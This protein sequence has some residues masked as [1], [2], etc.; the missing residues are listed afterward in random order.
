M[1]TSKQSENKPAK[2]NSEGETAVD[3]SEENSEIM[4]LTQDINFFQSKLDIL[5]ERKKKIHL[6]CDQ[7]SGW[8]SKVHN[9]MS[10]L[11]DKHS[12]GTTAKMQMSE[13]FK[14]ISEM[15]S[16]QLG[17]IITENSRKQKEDREL[18]IEE[19]SENYNLA[20][21]FN[22]NNH[23]LINDVGTEEFISKN[24]RVRPVSGMTAHENQD[25]KSN[26]HD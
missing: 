8:A 26:M 25:A 3:Q 21:D 10:G 16:E 5:Q 9:K 15:V 1:T 13:I 2:Q 20:E 17:Q 12:Y 4:Q 6:V 14:G 24:I 11:L 7:V 22:N 19:A 23:D 18:G